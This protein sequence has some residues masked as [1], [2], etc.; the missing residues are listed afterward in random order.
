MR[1]GGGWGTVVVIIAFVVVVVGE[2]EEEEG[3]A[4]RWSAET[5]AL[6][7][8]VISLFILS[9]FPWI[10]SIC[11]L[12]IVASA[13]FFVPSLSHLPFCPGGN[14]VENEKSSRGISTA[15]VV[16]VCEFC[17]RIV[18]SNLIIVD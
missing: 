8:C 13:R 18:S 10:S 3:S 7:P 1:R 11:S 12:I 4:G 9:M 15:P 6:N 16:F 5:A 14:N 17:A 2:E